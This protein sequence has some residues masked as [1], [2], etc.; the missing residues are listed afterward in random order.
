MA[1]KEVHIGE[2][3]RERVREEVKEL[4]SLPEREREEYVKGVLL[5]V[6]DGVCEILREGPLVRKKKKADKFLKELEE[7]KVEILTCFFYSVKPKF[8]PVYLEWLRR[9]AGRKIY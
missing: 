4:F 2:E 8:R 3:L 5:A 1:Q 6:L 7:K 9:L